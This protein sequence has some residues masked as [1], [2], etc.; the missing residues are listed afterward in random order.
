MEHHHLPP[1]LLLP[2]FPP[3][4][5]LFAFSRSHHADY[6]CTLAA[7]LTSTLDHHHGEETQK[8]I[9]L[10]V[11]AVCT[12]DSFSEIWTWTPLCQPLTPVQ[13]FSCSVFICN[14]SGFGSGDL[15]HLRTQNASASYVGVHADCHL[16][17]CGGDGTSGKC[18]TNPWSQTEPRAAIPIPTPWLQLLAAHPQNGVLLQCSC[19]WWELF[20][21]LVGLF[22]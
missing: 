10:A 3:L 21:H 5:P 20:L 4:P 17:A 13:F 12:M 16:P 6:L 1:S 9:N 22:V 7:P 11:Q 14:R 15:C 19:T 18:Q 2:P 8:E